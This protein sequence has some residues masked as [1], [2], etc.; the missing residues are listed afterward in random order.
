MK[1]LQV[2]AIC[3]CKVQSQKKF[4][5]FYCNDIFRVNLP[6]CSAILEA[7]ENIRE[8]SAPT[9]KRSRKREHLALTIVNL[10]EDNPESDDRAEKWTTDAKTTSNNP[11]SS[12]LLL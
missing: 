2:H 1:S 4:T 11:L 6:V 12:S 8:L 3:L 7:A 5:L 9:K 10:R